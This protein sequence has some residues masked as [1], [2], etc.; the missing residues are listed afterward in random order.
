MNKDIILNDGQNGYD[1]VAEHVR[2]YWFEKVYSTVVVTLSIADDG[3]HYTKHNEVVSPINFDDCEFLNDWWEGEKYIKILGIKDI[4][5]I[6]L[7]SSTEVAREIFEEIENHIEASSLCS[8]DQKEL[9]DLFG[10]IKLKYT[11]GVD[12][13]NN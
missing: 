9:I 1:A 12:G 7:A 2:K 13:K 11:E 8:L 5:E 6:E 4:D 10:V 3:K